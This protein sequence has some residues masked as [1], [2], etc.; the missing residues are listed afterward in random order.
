MKPLS[1]LVRATE[2]ECFSLAACLNGKEEKEA[3]PK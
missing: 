1:H 3:A 2:E